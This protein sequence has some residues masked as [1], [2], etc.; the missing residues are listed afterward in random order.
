[1]AKQM[2][3]KHINADIK[4]GTL[5]Q[6]TRTKKLPNFTNSPH[7]PTVPPPHTTEKRITQTGREL[8]KQ[9][10]EHANRAFQSSQEAHRKSANSSEKP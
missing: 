7:T 4:I 10:L 5:C 2:E 9:A 8:S 3:A 6:I 1:M